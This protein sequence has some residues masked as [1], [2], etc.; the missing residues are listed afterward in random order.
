M[1]KKSFNKKYDKILKKGMPKCWKKAKV[2]FDDDDCYI[3]MFNHINPKNYPNKLIKGIN[4][5]TGKKG[6]LGVKQHIEE[7]IDFL[8]N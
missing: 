4:K 6:L 1:F 5:H 3:I 8:K 7:L 2:L